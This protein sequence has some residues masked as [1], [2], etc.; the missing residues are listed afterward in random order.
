MLRRKLSY[1]AAAIATLACLFSCSK[2]TENDLGEGAT[3]TLSFYTGGIETRAV[4][5]GD[6]DIGDGGGIYLDENGKPDLIILIADANPKSTTYGNIVKR[7]RGIGSSHDGTVQSSSAKTVNVSFNFAQG[8]NY[9][10]Y[11]LANTRG[12]WD[13]E[14][15]DENAITVDDL[16]DN[17]EDTKVPTMAVLEDLRF[18][19]L[20]A[21]THPTIDEAKG[22][23]LSAEGDLVVSDGHN[24]QARLELLRCVARV[25]AEFI[26][27]SG[28]DLTISNYTNEIVNISPDCG[29]VIKHPAVSPADATMGKLI[30]TVAGPDELKNGK[31]ISAHWYTFPSVGPYTCNIS[32]T[33][34]G[35]SYTFEGLPVT[36][37]KRED[38]PCL[39][40]NQQLHIVTRISKGSQVSFN[41]QVDDWVEK[42]AE[43]EFD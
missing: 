30:A 42:T 21:N 40:R 34:N 32:F 1:I 35:K 6:G 25:T 23:P 41:F 10:V 15:A 2:N 24:G 13:M 43:V 5:P 8:G 12:F 17:T 16:M 39:F 19:K 26:N 29:Y 7:F 4:T 9:V 20:A 36:N 37:N 18:K 31:S 11:A 28:E 14:D 27:N 3:V 33:A 38:I 22:M